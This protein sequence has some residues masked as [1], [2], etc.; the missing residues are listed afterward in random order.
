MRFVIDVY[1]ELVNKMRMTQRYRIINV[2]I[3]LELSVILYMLVWRNT[4]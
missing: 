1:A 2:H 4:A 3:R